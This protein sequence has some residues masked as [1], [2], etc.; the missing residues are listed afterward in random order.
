ML[1]SSAIS[2]CP[3]KM[4]VWHDI[5]WCHV[6]GTVHSRGEPVVVARRAPETKGPHTSPQVLTLTSQVVPAKSHNLLGPQFFPFS[7]IIKM[8]SIISKITFQLYVFLD[9]L[10]VSQV[11]LVEIHFGAVRRLVYPLPWTQNK[12]IR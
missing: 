11:G 9:V 3:F 7:Q 4:Y 6:P 8:A 5:S 2:I 12:T 1:T 10:T